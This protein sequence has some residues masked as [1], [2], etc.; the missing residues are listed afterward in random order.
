MNIHT[1]GLC[2]HCK[3]IED[4]EHF[5][6]NCSASGLNEIIK[7]KCEEINVN[8]RIEEVLNREEIL[9]TVYKSIKRKL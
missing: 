1:D 5:L 4:T 7:R 8:F 2:N 3:V 9:E 6:M